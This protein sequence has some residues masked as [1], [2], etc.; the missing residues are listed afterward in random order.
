LEASDVAAAVPLAALV[1]S[2]QARTPS[3]LP[4]TKYRDMRRTIDRRA[5]SVDVHAA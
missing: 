2:P 4:Q 3:T 5:R 1:G